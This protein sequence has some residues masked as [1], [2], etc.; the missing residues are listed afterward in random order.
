MRYSYQRLTATFG[1][2]DPVDWPQPYLDGIVS[3]SQAVTV[4][5]GAHYRDETQGVRV[6]FAQG[7]RAPNVDDFAKFREQNG[8]IQVP[9]VQLAP[10]RSNTLEAAYTYSGDR[11]QIELT[12]YVTAL[13]AAIVRSDGSLPDGRTS[14]VSRGDTLLVDTNVNTESA[15]VYGTDVAANY[16]IASHWEV[17]TDLH[18]LRGRRSLD[19][20]EERALTLPQD[21]IPPAY[22]R[23]G[24]HYANGPLTVSL[25]VDAQV[26]KPLKGLCGDHRNR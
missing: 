11:L 12:A 19:I 2:E 9:N 16:R 14:F 3:G 8:R 13:S 15:W 21:H 4:A 7:F 23:A 17:R 22:G 18:W 6:L 26:R 5:L 20:D 1:A 25:R 10:E 24:L